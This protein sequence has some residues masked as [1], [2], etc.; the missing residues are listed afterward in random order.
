MSEDA[1]DM[2]E[3]AG[4]MIDFTNVEDVSFEVLPKGVYSAIIVGCEFKHS[5]KGNPMW[6]MQM[7]VRDGDY[8]GRK[9]F[10]HVTFS[11]AALPF[12]KKTLANIAPDLLETQF[13]PD[14]PEVVARFQNMEVNA[15]VS[16]G[17]YNNEPSN[18]VEELTLAEGTNFG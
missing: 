18:S 15:K 16:V 4:I 3:G 7:D 10:F 1:L 9:L 2:T 14:D 17:T 13:S 6:A 5:S 8:E 12:A 11:E